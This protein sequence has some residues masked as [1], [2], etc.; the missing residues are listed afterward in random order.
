MSL[1][2]Y[3]FH[4]LVDVCHLLAVVY[5]LFSLVTCWLSFVNE[6]GEACKSGKLDEPGVPG[7]LDESGESD[8]Y[9]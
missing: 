6:N 5:N 3:C 2:D 9:G 4:L 8:E 7:E 1:V